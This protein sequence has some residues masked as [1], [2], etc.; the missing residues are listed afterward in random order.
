MFSWFKEL[1]K[2]VANY[3]QETEKL[4]QQL[5]L[6]TLENMRLSDE[7]KALR[8]RQNNLDALVKERTTI[9]ADIGYTGQN[10]IIV[11]G[12]YKDADY[13]QTVNMHDKEFS[14]LVDQI[15]SMSK[16]G[17][18]KFVDAM[19]EVRKTVKSFASF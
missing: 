16:F 17:K 10:H 3:T 7:L 14:A 6:R 11:I 19:P 9:S 4:K 2:I 15:R 5:G 18:L 8:N 1:R 12:R 13:I